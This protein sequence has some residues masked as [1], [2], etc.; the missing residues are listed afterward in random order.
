MAIVVV[1]GSTKDIGKTALVC[2]IISALREFNWTA[3]KITAHY[4]NTES[5]DRT[6]TRSTHGEETTEEGTT[7][8]SRYL[9]AG[10]QR[11]LL[12]TRHGAQIPLKEIERD[13]G[14]DCNVIYESNRIA[15]VVKPGMCLALVGGPTEEW[16]PSFVQF[17]RRADAL[18]SFGAVEI[19]SVMLRDGVARFALKSAEILPPEMVMW[20]R[21]RLN[22]CHPV[23]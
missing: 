18:V 5:V 21:E 8:T 1:G 12:V 19:E 4:Y 3:V 23:S 22:G 11:S 17:L 15:D 2:A 20:M 13:V 16:K 7:D 14:A 6:A 9:A 10:A